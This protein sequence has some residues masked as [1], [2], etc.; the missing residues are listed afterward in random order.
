MTRDVGARLART[1]SATVA[2]D[3][4]LAHDAVIFSMSSNPEPQQSLWNRNCERTIINSNAGGPV[5]VNPLEMDGG[6]VRIRLQQ[7]K[8]T[9]RDSLHWS[10]QLAIRTPE[11]GRRAML[12]NSVERPASCSIRA[13]SDRR[14][15]LPSLASEA[16]CRSHSSASKRA[17][18]SRMAFNSTWSS[19]T[20]CCSNWSIRLIGTTL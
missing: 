10:R 2:Q 16:I 1:T 3:G 19:L 9:I 11:I 20:I 13:R 5:V 7:L 6:V 17:N 18:H 4:W 8:G 12:H 14:A 15:N